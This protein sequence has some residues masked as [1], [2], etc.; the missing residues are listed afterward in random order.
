MLNKNSKR[1]VSIAHRVLAFC[2]QQNLGSWHLAGDAIR[3][4]L[5]FGRSPPAGASTD[6]ENAS[7]LAF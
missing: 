2:L 5:R 4:G 1:I 3:H 7:G 6:E